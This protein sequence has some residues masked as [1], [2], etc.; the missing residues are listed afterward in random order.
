MVRFQNIVDLPFKDLR[1][2]IDKGKKEIGE[3][4]VIIYSVFISYMLGP[5]SVLRVITSS[6]KSTSRVAKQ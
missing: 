1:K 3:G 4:L 2:L 5:F 6:S